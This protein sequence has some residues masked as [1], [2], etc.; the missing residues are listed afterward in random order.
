MENSSV[1]KCVDHRENQD[2]VKKMI[3]EQMVGV[4]TVFVALFVVVASF[5]DDA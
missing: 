4:H 1:L 5:V 2:L 3:A